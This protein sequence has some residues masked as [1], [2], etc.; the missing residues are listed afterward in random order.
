VERRLGKTLVTNPIFLKVSNIGQSLPNSEAQAGCI[1]APPAAT[2][3][4]RELVVLA[5]HAGKA[6]CPHPNKS[7]PPLNA[8]AVLVAKRR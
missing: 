7:W 8:L 5:P 6:S 3:G 1:T 2:I 4:D